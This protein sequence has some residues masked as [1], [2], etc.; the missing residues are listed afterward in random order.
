[1]IAA[2]LHSTGMRRPWGFCLLAHRSVNI[3]G[4]NSEE[5]SLG[6]GHHNVDLEKEKGREFQEKEQK[7]WTVR[8]NKDKK[9]SNE[10]GLKK[11]RVIEK[12]TRLRG[13]RVK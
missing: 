1:M 2:A 4:I 7:I 9:G 5:I 10:I 8:P 11:T 3:L 13:S 12:S 6:V